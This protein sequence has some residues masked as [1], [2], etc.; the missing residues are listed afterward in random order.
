[1]M[2]IN[3][4]ILLLGTLIYA[5]EY[6]GKYNLLLVADWKTI[7]V[8]DTSFDQ[9][10]LI[11][12]IRAGDH[13]ITCLSLLS[14]GYFAVCSFKKIQIFD[15]VNYEC[16]NTLKGHD[17]NVISLILMKDKRIYVGLQ[18]SAWIWSY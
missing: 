18:Y 1:M 12:I 13:G 16:I 3:F 4:A 5:L 10:Q 9:Y 11:K 6:V 14:N 8:W 17:N 15:L 7:K 2:T